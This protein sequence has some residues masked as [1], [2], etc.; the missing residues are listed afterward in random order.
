MPDASQGAESDGERRPGALAGRVRRTVAFLVF[1]ASLAA[2][3]WGVG[4][5]AQAEVL[6]SNF[7]GRA[8]ST[9]ARFGSNGVNRP[10]Q[11]FTT[12]T[13]AAGYTLTSIEAA[14]VDQ[15]LSSDIGDLSVKVWSVDGSGHPQTM[16]FELDNPTSIAAAAATSLGLLDGSEIFDVT[17][18]YA[19]FTAPSGTT[20]TKM[21]EYAVVLTF[22]QAGVL[23]T[24]IDDTE[25]PAATGW[26]IA[27]SGISGGNGGT[28]WGNLYLTTA[29]LIRVNGEAKAANIPPTSDNK[30]VTATEDTD[31]TF[32]S[33]DFP[34]MDT[35]GGTLS[36]VKIVTLPASGKGTLTLDTTPVTANQSV[37]AA[38]LGTL[39]YAPPLNAN[40]AG[41]ASFT[42]KVN[43]GT[44]DSTTASTLTIDVT[45]VNDLATGKPVITGTARVG[46]VLT[47]MMGDI[48]DVEGLGTF[49]YQ[50]IRV[51][52]GT[53]SIIP[54]ATVNTYTLM[55]ADEGKTIKVRFSFT[56]GGNNAESRTSDAYPSGGTVLPAANIPPTSDNK[57][58]TATEDTDYTF[59][60]A[61][62]PF[63][64][65]DGGTLSS[66][67]IVTLPASGKGT[68]TLDTT[69]VTANQSVPAADLGTLKYAP[70][71]NANGAG[72]ASF[73]FKVNDGT[74]DSTTASTL[75]IDVTA[76]NDPATGKPVITGT[77]RVG[78]VLTAMM[79]DIAD[80]EGL[81]TFTYQWIRVS[82]GT[83][84]IIPG[85]TVN[86]Y[87]LMPADEGKTIKVR[88]SFTD[89]GNN[90]ESRTSDAY[91]SGGTVLPAA[92]IPPTSDNKTVTATEDTDY[93]FSSADFPFMDTDGGTLSSVKIVT[94][95]AS[96]KGTLTLDTT[97]VTAN[98]SV[99][100]ADL[101]TLKYAPPL[102]ANGAGYASFT[103][104]VNDGTDDST[105][106]NTLT[107][108]VTAVN[109][110]AT[111]KP[112]ITG[113]AQVGQVLTAMMGDIA[114]VEGLGTFTY[115]WIRVSSGTDS[116]ISGATV[117]TYTLMPADEGKTIK[118]RFSFT[119]GGN[120]AES[121]TSDAY[122][123]SG[124]VLPAT[125]IP[126]TSDNKTVTATEDT[127]YT[128]SSADFPFTDDDG[129]GVKS[130]ERE[131]RDAA[132][133]G[134]A[135]AR[136]D[137]RDG[138]PV[139][140]RGQ[141]RHP[142]IR[143]ALERQRG[144]LREFHLQGERRHGRQYDS[145]YADHQR[146]G[147]ERPGD[148]QARDHGHGAGRPGAD[149][150]D[151]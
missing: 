127:D 44:D 100:A 77:A 108:D 125:N 71:L 118:V 33:A 82:S 59:S 123:S 12:G 69:P 9:T 150:D 30:T 11:V 6:V 40:G 84:S 99:P 19:M 57:T 70:P 120:N 55:P 102:N 136:H 68:L 112:V 28:T 62:F 94:L 74:D 151:G 92:N 90:A 51:S 10:A 91:P 132:G 107:I 60:S 46:Q 116:I 27:D 146:D 4:G 43:D 81:G 76:V 103:F 106:A 18:N 35:D 121:R 144:R 24:T 37:P 142:E 126:P 141:P 89:G 36:S 139:G 21:T 131:D 111:G 65:T 42:F 26:S 113:T 117:N 93:T 45:A 22:D 15:V 7:D 73:T 83:D 48:A 130:L 110:P 52:S 87:T 20:L 104:K 54:G 147:G 105:T 5:S 80:V 17:G 56:D 124:M 49:T 86:T 101:G 53:D 3:L 61:D 32:S 58:V 8:T 137:S 145:E 149:R 72:Y 109:D 66:V 143:P 39:K 122:P 34:F 138:E 134:H 31:Y 75:T 97:P 95:P 129:D 16:Q 133:F 47:A 13:H 64:D 140:A 79:G 135:H 148:G 128:F 29:I 114:D 41:Y 38:D 119:D 78:Q 115:Q 50:W 1:C 98:Q 14:F 88:F 63:M 96:G 67:K 2:P 23:W 25:D 85:A